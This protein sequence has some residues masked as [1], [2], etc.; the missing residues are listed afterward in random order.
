MF[1]P[2]YPIGV[3]CE[4]GLVRVEVWMCGS[5]CRGD[6][7]GHG[8]KTSLAWQACDMPLLVATTPLVHTIEHLHRSLLHHGGRG[9]GGACKLNPYP[10][11]HHLP[12][13]S[14]T[15]FHDHHV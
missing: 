11:N 13:C 6:G 4:M 1:I 2:L 10:F 8:W 9:A 7:S 3:A 5:V 14:F 15:F 12:S